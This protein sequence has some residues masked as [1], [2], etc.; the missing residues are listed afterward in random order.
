M[1]EI[2]G[3]VREKGLWFRGT[4]RRRSQG[5]CTGKSKRLRRSRDVYKEV[6][7]PPPVGERTTRR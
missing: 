1:K 7:K 2:D 4:E 6:D 5:E 3:W